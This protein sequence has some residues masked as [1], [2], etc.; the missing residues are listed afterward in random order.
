MIWQKHAALASSWSLLRSIQIM[1]QFGLERATSNLRLSVPPRV[2]IRTAQTLSTI[3]SH[4]DSDSKVCLWIN[5]GKGAPGLT[6]FSLLRKPQS[7]ILDACTLHRRASA[8]V[9]LKKSKFLERQANQSPLSKK[10]VHLSTHHS[11]IQNR[12]GSKGSWPTRSS[13]TNANLTVL[14][15]R[16][17]R[18]S[19]AWK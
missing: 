15:A 2:K 6:S 14:R 19:H 13:P 16:E 10:H 17:G 3:G 12:L 9:G 7:L 1:T 4:S 11:T 18:A 5:Q 8:L